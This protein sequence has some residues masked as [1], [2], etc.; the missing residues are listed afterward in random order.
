MLDV[1]PLIPSQSLQPLSLLDKYLDVY[2]FCE[3]TK[4]LRTLEIFVN[5]GRTILTSFREMINDRF[6]KKRKKKRKTNEL[7]KLFLLNKRIL[8]KILTNR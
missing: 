6:F 5:D 8:Q 2:R 1:I 7:E 4:F 3:R